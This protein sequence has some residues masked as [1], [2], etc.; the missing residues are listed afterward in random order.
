LFKEDTTQY[1][2]GESGWLANASTMTLFHCWTLERWWGIRDI[3]P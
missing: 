2:T 1:L 3:A